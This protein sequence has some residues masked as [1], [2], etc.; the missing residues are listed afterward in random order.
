MNTPAV[1][2]AFPL[3][4]AAPELESPLVTNIALVAAGVLLIGC[5]LVVA[6]SIMGWCKVPAGTTQA[7]RAYVGVDIEA[8][9]PRAAEK[10]DKPHLAGAL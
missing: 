9:F 10:A 7:T 3:A 6:G 2:D 5:G 1:P 8:L 4:T